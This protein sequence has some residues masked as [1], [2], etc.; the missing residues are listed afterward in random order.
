MPDRE[1][2]RTLNALKTKKDDLVR[3][4]QLLPL[5]IELQSLKK[6]KTDMENQLRETETGIE[7]F[8]RSKVYVNTSDFERMSLSQAA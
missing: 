5:V 3:E 6:R 2:M 4:I 7:L 8:S 1:R